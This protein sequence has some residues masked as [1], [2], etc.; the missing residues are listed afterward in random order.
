MLHSEQG[1]EPGNLRNIQALI[2]AYTNGVLKIGS[3]DKSLVCYFFNGKQKTEWLN[4]YDKNFDL[5]VLWEQWRKEEGGVG[6]LWMEVVCIDQLSLVFC[7]PH[8]DL[9]KILDD[10]ALPLPSKGRIPTNKSAPTS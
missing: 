9:L 8:V 2:E 7:L 6:R 10:V 4:M 3:A 5:E 1:Q